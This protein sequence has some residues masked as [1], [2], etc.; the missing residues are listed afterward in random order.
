MS[1]GKGGVGKSSVTTNLA[2]ALANAGYKV[3]IVDA[4]IYGYSI[5]RM[6]GTDRDPVVI[7]N[8]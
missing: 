3:G 6:L 7:D 4:D 5:P 2:V 8:M 1:S